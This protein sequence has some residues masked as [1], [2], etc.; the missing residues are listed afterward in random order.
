MKKKFNSIL[1]IIK[2]AIFLL[3]PLN[4][5]A[6]TLDGST[7]LIHVPYA[8][9]L[10]KG[11]LLINGQTGTT[12]DH[13]AFWYYSS[14]SQIGAIYGMNK[15]WDLWLNFRGYQDNVAKD[16]FGWGNL[17]IGTKY[18]YYN[19]RLLRYNLS[20]EFILIIPTARWANIPWEPYHSGQLEFQL[21]ALGTYR[22]YYHGLLGYIF[23]NDGDIGFGDRECDPKLLEGESA[24]HELVVGFGAEYPITRHILVTSAELTGRFIL[25]PKQNIVSSEPWIVLTMG[26]KY[27]FSNSLFIS[28][29]ID[30]RLVGKSNDEKIFPEGSQSNYGF[31]KDC[32]NY[33]LWKVFLDFNWLAYQRYKIITT[34]EEE[35]ELAKE[36]EEE[37]SY[38]D[39]ITDFGEIGM[40]QELQE[41]MRLYKKL[42]QQQKETKKAEKEL[43]EIR[44][45]RQEA[46]KELQ[47][48]RKLLEEIE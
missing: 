34:E 14:I 27:F 21:N 28:A 17:K 47:K 15:G 8:T 26:I 42:K 46:E 13:G 18:N 1:F 44:K 3:S 33:P 31:Y 9:T 35:P 2:L 37:E 25:N 38:I 39:I 19:N 7:G 29:G 48:L 10:G 6:T 23:H 30:L 32:D 11:K 36:K 16:Y 41:K 12:M 43:N 4:I 40:S 5:F 45:K 24:T 22:K 20:G